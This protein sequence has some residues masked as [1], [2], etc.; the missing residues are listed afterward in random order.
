MQKS[1]KA[2]KEKKSSKLD[3]KHKKKKKRKRVSSSDSGSSDDSDG[4]AE[5]QWVEKDATKK[6]P[7]ENGKREKRKRSSSSSSEDEAAVGPVPKQHVTL[8]AKEYGKALLPGEGAAMAAYVAEGRRIP[9]RGEIGLTSGEIDSYE[10]V[11]Y[12]MSG[13]R[14]VLQ[15]RIAFYFKSTVYNLIISICLGIVAW[16]LCVLGKKIKFILRT[17]NELWQC[18]VKRKGR[19]EKISFWDNLGK[20]LRKNWL[21]S[22]KDRIKAIFRFFFFL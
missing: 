10:S 22:R 15:A 1:K 20:W 13:S 5:M 8:S 6:K 11:G 16:R 17:R 18:S 9:R 21:K 3:K 14:Y 2:K 12:V 7:E 4:S 19:N